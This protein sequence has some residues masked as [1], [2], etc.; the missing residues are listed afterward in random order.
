[1]MDELSSLILLVE[2][3]PNDQTLIRRVFVKAKLTNP[4]QIVDDGDA[5]VGYLN[6]DGTYVDRQRHPLPVL[7]L[8]D[9][10]LPRRSGLEVLE[11]MRAQPSLRCIRVIVL[12]SSADGNDIAHAYDLGANSY[13][14]TPLAFEGLLELLRTAGL[15]WMVMNQTQTVS[16]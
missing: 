5:A 13:L 1:M 8:L 3:D 15:Y 12:T 2:D 11:W 10:K 4:L 7:I 9:L 14:V 6:G 16:G